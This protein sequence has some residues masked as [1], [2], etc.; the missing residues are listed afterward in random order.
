MFQGE[1]LKEIREL[2]G[3]SRIDLADKLGVTQQAVWQ[4]ENEATEPRIEILNRMSQLLGVTNR[5]FFAPD[6]LRSVATEEHVAYRSAD[7]E[8]RKTTKT[9]LTYLNFVDY[10]IKFY[11]QHLLVPESSINAIVSRSEKLLD[12]EQPRHNH[13]AITD[14]VVNLLAG[15]AQKWFELTDNRHLMYTLESSGIYIVEK[16]LG[17]AVDAYSAHTDD[18]RYYIILG[19]IK[20]TAVR[21]NFDL[22]HELG[23]ILMHRRLDLNELSTE[24]H[25]QIEHEANA[26]AAAFLIPENELRK[27]FAKLVRHSNP[28]Y[29]LDMKQKYLVSYQ[30]LGIRA[31]SLKLM[32]EKE[33]NYFMRQMSRKGY[34]RF[35]PLDDKIVPVRP[36]RIYSLLRLVF[37]QKIA[38]VTELTERFSIKPDFLISL[39]QLNT[40]FF[41]RYKPKFNYYGHAA[42]IIPFKR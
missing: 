35:E 19:K 9:E 23:H 7:Q 31:Y 26:F 3:Y 16:R 27:D 4:Y 5:Y 14:T 24:G 39:F 17:T 1:K 40:D 30:A 36:G 10:Y 29:F 2:E 13:A 21:R 37:D 38:T 22:A 6:Y 18:G 41:E 12:T 34:K 15:K 32:T 33:F 42:K 20:K 25:R 8:S 11:E 28:D